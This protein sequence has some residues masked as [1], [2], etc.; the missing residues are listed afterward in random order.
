MEKTL[1]QLVMSQTGVMSTVLSGKHCNRCETLHKT[2]AIA[3]ERLYLHKTCTTDVPEEL[4]VACVTHCE[5]FDNIRSLE[6]VRKYLTDYQSV[7]DNALAGKFDKTAQSHCQC[8]N[9]V[10]LQQIL[11]YVINISDSD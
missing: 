9:L 8:C 4:H 2:F 6:F 7:K 1:Y 10:N 5:E 11:D 3:M